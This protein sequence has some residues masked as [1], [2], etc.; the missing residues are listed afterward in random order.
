MWM[1]I[2]GSEIIESK[3][4]VQIVADKMECNICTC[5]FNK[6]TRM[7]VIC[8][9]CEFEACKTCVR[10]YLVTSNTG[11]T[12][13]C[14][15]CAA[16]LS[17]K[18]LVTNLNR[19]WALSG[20]YKETRINT[21]IDAEI[22][23]IPDTIQA[24]EAE[25]DRRVLVGQ[26]TEFQKQIRKLDNQKQMYANAI[27][28]NQ[29]LMR[30][31][32]VPQY[33]MTN[34]VTGV[35]VKYGG[36][37]KKFIMACPGEECKG[38]L[39]TGY[40]CGLCENF[41]CSDC[42]VLIG[43][44]KNGDHVC[45]DADK[46]SAELIR[47]E[48]KACP[49][50]GERIFKISGC[51]QM[52]CTSCHCAFSWNTGNI[53]TGVVHNPHFYEIQRQGGT[54][55]RN[56]GDVPCG[57][58][59]NPGRIFRILYRMGSVLNSEHKKLPYAETAQDWSQKLET[60]YRN[61]SEIQ[62]Y[63]INRYRNQVREHNDVGQASRIQYILGDI[64]KNALGM[65]SYKQD[66]LLQQTTDKIH[67]LEILNICGI[68][69]FRDIVEDQRFV[70]LGEWWWAKHRSRRQRDNQELTPEEEQELNLLV[71]EIFAHIEAS[72]SN[73]NKVRLYCNEQ[74]K[75]LS[76]TYNVTVYKFDE[77]FLKRHGKKYTLKG[78]LVGTEQRRRRAKNIVLA[79]QAG[80]AEE[81][82]AAA[83]E[84]ELVAAS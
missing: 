79:S 69:T 9:H 49:G 82:E 16:A 27:V 38:F 53:E 58:M 28:A 12:P 40:K 63:D 51:D 15:S 17:L 61:L 78:E 73:L 25:K 81:P 48:T 20:K 66:L 29:Y 21:L 46:S 2:Y 31:R 59:P 74:L 10:T 42:L 68:E 54:I 56:A 37:K 6:G 65:N 14:M 47:K 3:K 34:L 75:E 32:D 39:S 44:T 84:P 1:S 57:G 64:D 52:F 22:G 67:I 76:I 72:I 43:K 80:A 60:M 4:G 11:A 23:K 24:A 35:P 5:P 30:G 71:P 8:G 41:S 55:M 33:Y 50:C 26:N 18:F 36:D 13:K 83:E 45:N 77:N 70:Q 7:K 19:S 62:Q